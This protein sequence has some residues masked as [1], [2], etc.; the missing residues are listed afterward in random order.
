MHTSDS[1]WQWAM[2]YFNSC[3]YT[4][5]EFDTDFGNALHPGRLQDGFV[6][7]PV[8][9]VAIKEQWAVLRTPPCSDPEVAYFESVNLAC[10]AIHRHLQHGA[11]I[12]K[13]P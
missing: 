8:G 12:S 13:V 7:A 4:V 3:G 6:V 1:P 11:P 5:R 10:E 9:L 2:D